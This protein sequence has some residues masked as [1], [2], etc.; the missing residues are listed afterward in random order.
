MHRLG[1]IL[2]NGTI[3]NATITA[4]GVSNVYMIGLENYATVNLAG[5][6]NVYMKPASGE[7]ALHQTAAVPFQH[8]CLLE[9]MLELEHSSHIWTSTTVRVRPPPA[10]GILYASQQ[11]STGRE[12]GWRNV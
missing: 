12:F 11:S 10:E 6:A 4:S 1:Q 5:T 3:T 9:A 7:I 8:A 2:V